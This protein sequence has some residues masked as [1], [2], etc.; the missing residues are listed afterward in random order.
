LDIGLFG[1]NSY[2]L[3]G[4]SIMFVA[5][6]LKGFS[7]PSAAPFYIEVEP[8]GEPQLSGKEGERAGCA[9]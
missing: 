4:V 1:P 7:F 3:V 6:R 5:C 2:I 9:N 8:K